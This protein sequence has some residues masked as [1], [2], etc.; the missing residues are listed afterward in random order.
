MVPEEDSITDLKVKCE[1][2]KSNKKVVVEKWEVRAAVT[3]VNMPFYFVDNNRW[4]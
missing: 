3:E 4:N 2:W 1:E